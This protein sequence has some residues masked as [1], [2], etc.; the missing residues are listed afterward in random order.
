MNELILPV[1]WNLLLSPKNGLVLAHHFW[2]APA[3][4]S[5]GAPSLK[6]ASGSSRGEGGVAKG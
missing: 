1:E 2:G 3:K 6:E 5:F 4:N